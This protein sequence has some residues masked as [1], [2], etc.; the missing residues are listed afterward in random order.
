[1]DVWFFTTELENDRA[2][3]FRQSRWCNI[4]L[5]E[6]VNVR[7]FNLHGAFSFLDKTFKNYSEFEDFRK[8][9]LSKRSSVGSVRQGFFSK[10]ARKIKHTFLLDLFYPN[11]FKLFFIAFFEILKSKESIKIISS[12]P[13]FSVVVVGSILKNIFK[14]KVVFTI[15]MRDAWALHDS[16]GGIK[17]IKKYIEKKSIQ[18][19]DYIITVSKWLA[20]EFD[21]N[22]SVN[23]LTIYNVATHYLNIPIPDKIDICKY[24]EKINKSSKKIVY[25]GSTPV[26]FYDV[27]NIMLSIKTVADSFPNFSNKIQFIFVGNCEE[28]K[29]AANKLNLNN[30]VVFINHVP[31][32]EVR[33]IQSSADCLLFLGYN[34]PENKGV[35]STK[36]FEYLFL[37][38]CILPLTIKTNSDVDNIFMT[39]C[40][41]TIRLNTIEE[42][43]DFINCLLEDLDF[44]NKTLKL[45]D[46]DS[47]KLLIND[48]KEFAKRLRCLK[49]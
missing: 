6:N 27:Y 43:G 12:S 31:Q 7:V 15:D 11:I 18:S 36:L 4:F 30:E 38:K 48:Y 32:S 14:E 13:P 35:V 3:S 19:A 44:E 16:L 39:L 37:N 26:G 2:S 5:D 8:E 17:S 33:Q 40:N 20:S 45:K 47:A 34:G 25:T 29:L 42:I 41:K 49:S 21:E 28:T 22:Y 1:M 24:S 46:I 23:T 10:I 9:S